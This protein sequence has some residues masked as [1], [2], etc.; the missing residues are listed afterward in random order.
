MGRTHDEIPL[1]VARA[2]TCISQRLGPAHWHLQSGRPRPGCSREARLAL[3]QTVVHWHAMRRCSS[4]QH[5]HVMVHAGQR[6]VQRLQ[7][8]MPGMMV[9]HRRPVMYVPVVTDAE[10]AA[11]GAGVSEALHCT[12]WRPAS[13]TRAS[14]MGWAHVHCTAR[15][16]LSRDD[17]SSAPAGC[18]CPLAL[19]SH[20]IKLQLV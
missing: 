1:P 15:H 19:A 12:A 3:H 7:R 8:A 20:P 10:S 5:C 6:H 4:P 18:H 2:G 14:A 17:G 11:A 9:L 16:G 13:P